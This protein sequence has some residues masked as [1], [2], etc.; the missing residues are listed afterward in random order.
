MSRLFILLILFSVPPVHAQTFDGFKVLKGL[1][2]VTQEDGTAVILTN[3]GAFPQKKKSSPVT[4]EVLSEK[5][6]LNA[7]GMSLIGAR[8][9]AVF[10]LKTYSTA[11][12]VASRAG[13]AMD[14]RYISGKSPI[15]QF[16]KK[17]ITIKRGEIRF[18]NQAEGKSSIYAKDLNSYAIV[19]SGRKTITLNG[20]KA[21]SNYLESE[22]IRFLQ[23][24]L[25]K[26]KVRPPVPKYNESN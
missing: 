26:K 25:P 20:K 17:R 24:K 22:S 1:I 3:N 19:Q 23:P 14:L 4:V 13:A 10:E 16:G 12:I 7:S 11:G 6:V 2:R 18:S 8:K 15:V 21:K 9:G 5:A